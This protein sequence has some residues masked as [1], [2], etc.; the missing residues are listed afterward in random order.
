MRPFLPLARAGGTVLKMPLF[1]LPGRSSTLGRKA[2]S[3]VV[4]VH[5]VATRARS[6]STMILGTRAW[7]SASATS[8]PLHD[9]RTPKEL[10]SSVMTGYGTQGWK[11]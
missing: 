5:P 8:A 6:A 4:A 11:W 10:E 7:A 9:L 2:R 1:C 3:A